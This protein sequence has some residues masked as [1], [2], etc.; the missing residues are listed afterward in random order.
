MLLHFRIYYTQDI[1]DNDVP[2]VKGYN[3]T[4]KYLNKHLDP[5][6]N[7]T[8]ELYKFQ[9]TIQDSYETVEQFCYCLT[10]SSL[11]CIFQVNNRNSKTRFEIGSKLTK[12]IPEQR[13]WRRSGVSIVNFEHISH[14]VLVFLLLTLSR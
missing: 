10:S 7:D 1:I 6:T 12:K 14:L 2:K 8:F 5:K 3:A 11:N 4:V 13:Q 9:N